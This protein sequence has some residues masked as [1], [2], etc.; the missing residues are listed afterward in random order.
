MNP[1]VTTKKRAGFTLIELLVVIAIIAILASI[2]I[3]GVRKGLQTAQETQS[4]AVLQ[5]IGKAISHYAFD[6]LGANRGGGG[7]G[8]LPQLYKRQKM[9]NIG[10]QSKGRISYA[11]RDYFGGAGG[12]SSNTGRVPPALKDSG[13]ASKVKAS[14]VADPAYD[15]HYRWVVHQWEFQGE[16]YFPFGNPHSSLNVASFGMEQIET[17][18]DIWAIGELDAENRPPGN[19]GSL[20]DYLA[21][22][23]YRTRRCAVFFDAH[24]EKVPLADWFHLPN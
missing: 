21:T 9:R 6:H 3:A 16:S 18:S 17:P 5:S 13:W 22:P 12:L 7:N 24:V 1:N 11:L 19:G 8:N 20:S 15:K 2:L 10:S 4:A 14:H 23:L